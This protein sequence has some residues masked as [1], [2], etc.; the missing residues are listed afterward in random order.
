MITAP[1]AVLAAGEVSTAEQWIFWILAVVAII[2]ALG[3]VMA[4]NAVPP[5]ITP[6]MMYGTSSA[7]CSAKII[8]PMC[9]H[10]QR[11]RNI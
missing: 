11:S 8:V 7:A 1:Q 4:R 2:G 10:S 5:P 3:M 9:P 6:M